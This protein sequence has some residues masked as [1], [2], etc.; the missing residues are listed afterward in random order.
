[1]QRAAIILGSAE[2]VRKASG[3]EVPD[4]QRQQHERSIALA[5]EGLGQ[6]PYDA[7]VRARLWRLPR[8]CRGRLRRGGPAAFAGQDIV[9][10]PSTE[11]RLTKREME[12]AMLD[13]GRT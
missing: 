7:V 1:M 8:G 9:I 11:I 5:L 4:A 2:H 6:R 3:L 13:R 12:I 10:K